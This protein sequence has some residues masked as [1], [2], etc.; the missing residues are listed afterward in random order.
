M[1]TV[2]LHHLLF[3]AFHGIHEEEKILGNQYIVDA[4]VEFHEDSPVIH[5]IH[6]TVNYTDIYNIIRERM[7][8]PTPLLE[9]VV[10]EIGN[11]IHDE[12]PRLRSIYI[13]IKKLYPPIEGIR[14][15]AGVTWQ[16]QY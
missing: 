13:A 15:A 16:K 3:D 6:N 1:I 11:R 14:G 5:S 2:Q 9:T 7:N 12:F 4:S 8:V 10:M